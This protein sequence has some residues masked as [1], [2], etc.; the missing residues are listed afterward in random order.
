MR[1]SPCLSPLIT[2]SLQ[3]QPQTWR[4]LILFSQ[5]SKTFP[6]FCV[7]YPWY[8]QL[9]LSTNFELFFFRMFHLAKEFLARNP[10]PA[11]TSLIIPPWGC[12]LQMPCQACR[13]TT[14]PPAFTGRT[15][16]WAGISSLPMRALQVSLSHYPTLMRKNM[17][18][19]SHSLSSQLVLKSLSRRHPTHF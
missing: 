17:L 6:P 8:V 14:A 12:F 15:S 5:R 7:I 11:L 4:L 3:L 19:H 13:W 10:N 9:N 18:L 2:K 16:P 1:P